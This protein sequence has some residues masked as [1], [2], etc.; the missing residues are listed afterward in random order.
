M[1][2]ICQWEVRES[3]GT[4][5]CKPNLQRGE[6]DISFFY[7]TIPRHERKR[8][9]KRIERKR[10]KSRYQIRIGE[11]VGNKIKR[12]GKWSQKWY[13]RRWPVQHTI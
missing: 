11:G 9:L 2:H 13:G 4:S 6:L 3:K 5:P 7:G 12:L 10:L 1:R 8:K